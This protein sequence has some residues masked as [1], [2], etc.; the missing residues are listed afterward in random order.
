MAG[1]RALREAANR[2]FEACEASGEPLTLTGLAMALGIARTDL[3]GAAE[4][5]EAVAHAR[6]RVENAY[7]KRLIA[8]GNGGDV[9]AMKQFGWRDKKEDGAV[10]R[11]ALEEKLKE[12]SGERY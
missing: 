1:E 4:K 3:D 6:A 12:I 7:E 5:S 2:Y 8:R 9:F 11:A 10:S